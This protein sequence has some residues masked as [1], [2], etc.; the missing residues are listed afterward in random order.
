MIADRMQGCRNGTGLLPPHVAIIRASALIPGVGCGFLGDL[1]EIGASLHDPAKLGL[2]RG[3]G[4]K[5]G[6]EI[7][8]GE[9]RDRACARG[10]QAGYRRTPDHG[11]DDGRSKLDVVGNDALGEERRKLV[12]GAH[13]CVMNFFAWI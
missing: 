13:G 10:R 8:S 4:P 12:D 11:F 9:A 7:V 2:C 3:T 6:Q 5:D 1:G